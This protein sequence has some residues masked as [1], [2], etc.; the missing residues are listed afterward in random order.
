MDQ[1]EQYLFAGSLDKTAK[2]WNIKNGKFLNSFIG[3]LDYINTLICANSSKRGFTGSSDR[4]VK[5]WDLESKKLLKTFNGGSG[6]FSVAISQNDHM[7]LSGHSDGKIKL[8]SVNDNSKPEHVLDFHDDKVIS[9]QPLK[10]ENHII[11]LS[12]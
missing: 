9:I 11:S 1:S 12:K 8:W 10:N 6:C 5:E 7:L 3:H 2:L 4:T